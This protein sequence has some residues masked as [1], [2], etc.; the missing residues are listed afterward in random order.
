MTN[1]AWGAKVSPLFR[2]KTATI[3][4]DL[5]VDP[6]WLMSCMA[7]ESG[8]TFSP[9]IRNAAGS[10]AVG[11]I[12]FMPSTANALGTSTDQL[13][14]MTAEHQLDFVALYFKPQRGKLKNLGDVYMTILWPNGIG[15]PDSY[16]LFDRNDKQHPARYVQ[17]AGLDFNHDGVVTRGEAYAHVAAK[18]QKGLQPGLVWVG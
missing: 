9:N 6:S 5:Q 16:A 8:E 12:Q 3:A 1:L 14:A 7:F 18:L 4:I 2:G 17:N 13:A 15:K 10:G 11:L